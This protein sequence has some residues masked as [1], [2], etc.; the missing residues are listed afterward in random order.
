MAQSQP[1]G[2]KPLGLIESLTARVENL[3]ILAEDQ[4]RE[5]E[6]LRAEVAW[7]DGKKSEVTAD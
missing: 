7:R 2:N 4:A 5:I 3:E 6:Q 1:T